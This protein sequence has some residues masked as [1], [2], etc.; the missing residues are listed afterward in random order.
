MFA[1]MGAIWAPV[2]AA[3]GASALT[4]LGGFGLEHWRLARID[5]TTRRR[6][7]AEAGV[8]LLNSAME[9]VQM[10]NAL[11]GLIR[12]RSGLSEGLDVVTGIRK[13]LDLLELHQTFAL[14]LRATFDAHARIWT[15][16][17]ESLIHDANWVLQSCQFALEVAT[18]PGSER[19]RFLRFL[20]GVKWTETEDKELADALAGIGKARARFAERLREHVG[21]EELDLTA[22]TISG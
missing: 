8:A 15:V 17:D 19:G 7:I 21:S 22:P 2:V 9:V 6:E 18:R 16:G 13:P 12:F 11:R 10:A 3:L 20:A 1:A 5:R 14:A 4:L